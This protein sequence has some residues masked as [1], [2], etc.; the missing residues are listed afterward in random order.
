VE[1]GDS[2]TTRKAA[3]SVARGRL[4]RSRSPGP[5]PRGQRTGSGGGAC[6]PGGGGQLEALAS[7]SLSVACMR[8]AAGC[9]GDGIAAGCAGAAAGGSPRGSLRPL[10]EAQRLDSDGTRSDSVSSYQTRKTETLIRNT[11]WQ[12]PGSTFECKEVERNR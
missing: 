8:I 1:G 11:A 4:S 3:A 6:G 2:E 7:G 5:G 9:A 10:A 12:R